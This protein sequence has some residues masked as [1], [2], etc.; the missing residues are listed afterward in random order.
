[1]PTTHRATHRRATAGPAGSTG[2]P[3]TLRELSRAVSSCGG[4][5]LAGQRTRPVTGQG[6]EDARLVVVTAAPGR[7]EDLLG[8]PLAG[9]ARNVLDHALGVAGFDPAEVRL[10]AVVRCHAADDGHAPT[11]DEVAACSSHL[12]TELDLVRPEVVVTLGALATAVVLGRPVPLERVAGYRLD[13]RGGVTLVPTYHPT[14]AVR[15]L[16]QRARA[17]RRDLAVARAVLDGRMKSGAEAL[18]DLR[19]RLSAGN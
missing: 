1:V 8:V 15:G 10:T 16:D 14:D 4:C 11:R 7:Q 13:V 17:L 2:R 6:P 12:D 18:A 19:S 3:R 5:H 9:A